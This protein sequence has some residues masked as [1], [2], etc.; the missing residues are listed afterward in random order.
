MSQPSMPWLLV[1]VASLVAGSRHAAAGPTPVTPMNDPPVVQTLPAHVT[2]GFESLRLPGDERLGLLGTSYLI[3]LAPGW[4]LGPALYGAASG[5]RGGLFTWGVE[6]QRRW[7]LGDRWALVAGLYAGGGGGS[8]APVGGGLMLRPHADLVFDFG[9]W[10]AGIT[11]SQVRFPSGTIRSVQVGVLVAV[12]D[13]FV[14]T[15]PGQAGESVRFNGVGGIGANRMSAAV[16]RYATASSG[17]KS[18]DYV[19]I[20]LERQLGQGLSATF[21]AAGAAKGGADGYAE[22]TAGVL[23]LWPIG[24]EATRLGAH[25]ALGLGGGG[26]VPTGAGPI[27]KLGLAGRLQFSRQL[28]LEL[29]AG[30]ARAFSGDFNSHYAQLS[31]GVMLGGAPANAGT[32]DPRKTLHDTTWALSVQN[33]ARAQRKDGSAPG[34]STLGFRFARSLNEHVYLSG[35]AHSA[36]TGGAGAYSVGL[37]GMGL[38]TRLGPSTPW[39]IGAEAM[40]GAAGGGGVSLRGGAIAQPMVWVGR[41]LGRFSRITFGAGVV[42]SIRGELSSPVIDVSW[43]AEFGTP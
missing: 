2:L 38:T 26:A 7:P 6:G 17:G 31:L 18:L 27:A 19:G 25:A 9:G 15:A 16:G 21:S 28:S 5:Q 43:A 20:R 37:I 40:V 14:F 34:L 41:D 33:Y 1:V 3:E 30:Q 32:E 42:R 11:A 36:I 8:G 35:Q 23:A 12:H 39:K 22:A 24:S 10:E 4:W 29:E 13:E